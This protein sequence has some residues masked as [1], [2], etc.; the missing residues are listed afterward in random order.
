MHV[1]HTCYLVRACS[2]GLYVQLVVVP[3]RRLTFCL[4]NASGA[5]FIIF[6]PGKVANHK[7]QES[8]A[9]EVTNAMQHDCYSIVQFPPAFSIL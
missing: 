5:V 9:T 6:S 7:S 1:R 2:N 8:T 4:P 3:S